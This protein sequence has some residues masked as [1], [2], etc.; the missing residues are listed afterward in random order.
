MTRVSRK[1]LYSLLAC[2]FAIVANYRYF[3]F[4]ERL[5][6]LLHGQEHVREPFDIDLPEF[7]LSGVNPEAEVAGLRPG[8]VLRTIAG[9]PVRHLVADLWVPLRNARA[10]DAL[11]VDFWRPGTPVAR[12]QPAIV[13]LR[14][15]R[16][17]AVT[18]SEWAGFVIVG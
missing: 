5:G 18:A 12:T 8:D 4:T 2:F 17:G 9:R 15:L 1:V 6:D 13:R 10:G 14:A 11:R 16:E 7:S 3:D